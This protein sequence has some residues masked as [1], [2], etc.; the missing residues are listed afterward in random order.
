MSPFT[1]TQETAAH[2]CKV[3]SRNIISESILPD[4]LEWTSPQKK[5]S[6]QHLDQGLKH[7]SEWKSFENRVK[8]YIESIDNEK[9]I[10]HVVFGHSLFFAALTAYLVSQKEW[11]PKQH[12]ICFEIQN[13]YLTVL[14]EKSKK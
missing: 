6:Q 1:R 8:K 13:C 14:K 3:Y 10:I 12:Q 7:D 4:L 5:L 11:F 2:F 9:N